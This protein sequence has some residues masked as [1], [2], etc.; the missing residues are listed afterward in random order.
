MLFNFSTNSFLVKL[1]LFFSLSIIPFNA[2]HLE[3]WLSK[4]LE[5]QPEFS[6][7]FQTYPSINSSKHHQHYSSND[8]FFNAQLGLA[9]EPFELQLETCAANTRKRSFGMDF[10]SLNAFYLLSN[11]I[12]GD[13]YSIKAGASFAPAWRQAL[14]DISSFH[15]GL[16]EFAGHFSIGRE[17][18]YQSEWL[19]RWWSSFTL[20]Q[21]EQGYPWMRLQ[22]VWEKN[23][24]DSLRYRAFIETL[25]GFGPRSLHSRHFRGYGPVKHRSVDIGIASYYTICNYGTIKLE[26]SRRIFAYNFPRQ[27]NNIILSYLFPF[28]I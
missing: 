4:A 23:I 1:F 21:A 27:A 26:Y 2:L 25:W 11:D 22:G 28:G 9:V 24:C 7:R 5:F 13:P 15:H 17:S 6:Y 10:F 19:T 20:G 18:S 14:N 8:N 12:L 3:P 16:Y